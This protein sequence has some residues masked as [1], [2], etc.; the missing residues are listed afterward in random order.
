MLREAQYTTWDQITDEKLEILESQGY[1]NEV[2][3]TPLSNL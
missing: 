2:A 1:D 3:L